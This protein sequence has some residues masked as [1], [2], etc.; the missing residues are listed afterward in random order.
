AGQ[1]VGAVPAAAAVLC[2]PPRQEGFGNV[3][4]EAG[5]AGI[6]VVTSRRAGVSELLDGALDGLVV[7]DPED[8]DALRAALE[9]AL[10]PERA[11]LGAA[12][13]RLAESLP[14]EAHL[15]RVE[16]LLEEVGGAG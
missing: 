8:L 1:A 16:R 15:D 12:A 13:R 5:A 6:P 4:L 9:R 7:D 14:W 11:T 2:M 3:A 10:G